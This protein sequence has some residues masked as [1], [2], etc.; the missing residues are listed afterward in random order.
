MILVLR[1][2]R[3]FSFNLE[4]KNSADIL[5]SH[6]CKSYATVKVKELLLISEK[7]KKSGSV[8]SSAS[9]KKEEFRSSQ[10]SN[11]TN[12]GT[13][14]S[15]ACGTG[16][17]ATFKLRY[18]TL[19]LGLLVKPYARAVFLMVFGITPD[20]WNSKVYF[21]HSSC[22]LTK[23]FNTSFTDN[24]WCPGFALITQFHNKI[25][26]VCLSKKIFHLHP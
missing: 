16:K 13:G 12:T 2:R 5:S 10:S 4:A 11:F 17:M 25:C 6:W 24:V 3:C 21:F 20:H 26:I 22:P 14:I 1:W 15:V 23:S 19:F 7:S 9:D 18:W 8:A